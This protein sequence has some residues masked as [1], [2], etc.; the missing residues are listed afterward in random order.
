MGGSQQ[1]LQRRLGRIGHIPLEGLLQ[2]VMVWNI[3]LE[4]KSAR[5]EMGVPLVSAYEIVNLK[6]GG[7]FPTR[8]P[9]EDWYAS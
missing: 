2:I 4:P 3:L 9:V 6:D 7:N 8:R 1:A 5:A